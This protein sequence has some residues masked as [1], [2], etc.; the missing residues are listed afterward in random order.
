MGYVLDH[1]PSFPYVIY[2]FTY[3]VAGRA[4]VDI[5]SLSSDG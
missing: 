2:A 4:T 5:Y 1:G 3:I